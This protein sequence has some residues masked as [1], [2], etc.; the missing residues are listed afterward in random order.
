MF[1]IES[2]ALDLYNCYDLTKGFTEQLVERNPA[3]GTSSNCVSQFNYESMPSN[4]FG[5]I[6]GSG[7]TPSDDYHIIELYSTAP[8][9]GTTPD[10]PVDS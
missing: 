7:F 5:T 8:C 6:M 1:G 10:N 9:S 2:F 3:N 4:N